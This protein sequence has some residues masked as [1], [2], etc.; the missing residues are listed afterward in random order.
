M[1]RVS[2]LMGVYNCA[3]TVEKSIDSI[4]DQTF[5]DWEFIICD[6]GSKDNTA[7]VVQAYAEREPRIKFIQND[8]NHGLS[9]TLNHCLSVATGEYCARMDGDDLCDPTRFQKQI[10][11]LEQHPEYGFVSCRMTRFDENGT[12]D[13]P[14][15]IESFEPTMMDYIKGSPF[16]HAP[17]MIRKSSYDSVNGYRDI[18]ETL[19]VEDYDLWFRLYAAGIKGYMLQEPLYH[20][21]DGRGAAKRRTFK[22]RLNEAWVRKEGYKAIHAPMVTRVFILKPILIALIPQKIYILLLRK[23]GRRE[24]K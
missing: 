6:D 2:V 1:P 17:V 12:Y 24:H 13:V 18:P 11:F 20:M 15:Y 21:F 10:D 16:C 9:Y 14:E 8:R 4:V 23:N 22:R 5:T 19:C 3:N 7:A